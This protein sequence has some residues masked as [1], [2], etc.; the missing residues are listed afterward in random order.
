MTTATLISPAPPTAPAP[1]AVPAP[2]RWSRADYYRLGELG[3][4]DGKRVEL[5]RGEILA[6][7]PMGSRHAFHVLL[8]A[9]RLRGLAG[10]GC[11][12]RTQ[13]P[14]NL[15]DSEPEPDVAVVAG[16]LHDFIDAHPTT[17]LL[18][19]EMAETS[20][21]YD[22]TTK[23]QLY[24]AAGVPDYWVLDLAARRLHRFTGPTP[25]GYQAQA[26]LGEA[27]SVT[28]LTGGQIGVSE[29]LP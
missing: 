26:V 22:L 13:V 27:E 7:S 17:A 12:V 6:M 18:V 23:A 29:V 8:V 28:L 19:V 20:L 25:A 3:F 1:S 9:E 24:A 10:R 5:I 21:A 11:H 14:L 15:G 4:F 16:T 2:W